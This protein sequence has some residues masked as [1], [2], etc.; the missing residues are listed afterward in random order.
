[1]NRH[2]FQ[3]DHAI[4]HIGPCHWIIL[5]KTPGVGGS[6]DGDGKSGGGGGRGNGGDEGGGGGGSG[7][8]GGEIGGGGVGYDADIGSVIGG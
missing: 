5:C 8:R 2:D 4:H 7:D 1:M 3:R 6:G